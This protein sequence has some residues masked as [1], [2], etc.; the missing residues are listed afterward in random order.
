MTG[1][2]AQNL[3]ARRDRLP[4]QLQKAADWI[5]ANPREVALLSMREQARRAGVQPATMTRLAQALGYD[6]YEAVRGLH[7]DALR[8]PRTGLSASAAGRNQLQAASPDV[9]AAAML[10][11]TAAQIAAL[12]NP[13]LLS[14]LVAAAET[15]ADARQIY[16]LGLRSSHVV[17]WHV[18]YSLSLISDRAR[19][20]EGVG[21]VGLDAL[22][23]AQAGDV[24]F[25]CGV[26]PYTRAAVE[27]VMQARAQGLRVI[28]LTDS[29]LSPLV[30]PDDPALVVPTDS[31]SFLHSMGPAFSVAEILVALV[32][33]DDD[34]GILAR[35]EG[36]DHQLASFNTYYPQ[37]ARDLP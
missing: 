19:L 36:L 18:W 16:C 3:A 21:G 37:P 22:A 14:S 11:H 15:M 31:A 20:L 25:A 7:G 27:A 35:L 30:S 34:P 4:A 12:A 8:D 33:R 6:G 1:S 17:A 23:R 26:A 24:L 29:P 10:Q 28:A 9:A 5:V 13:H 2:F 32:A